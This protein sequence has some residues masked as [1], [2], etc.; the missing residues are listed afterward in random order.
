MSRITL[1]VLVI[2]MTLSICLHAQ[3]PSTQE[4]HANTLQLA[5]EKQFEAPVLNFVIS[6]ENTP[7]IDLVVTTNNVQFLTNE[8]AHEISTKS[9]QLNWLEGCVY[10]VDLSGNGKYVGISEHHYA[11]YGRIQTGSKFS[12]YDNIGNLLTT[13]E[14]T[15]EYKPSTVLNN[16]AFFV[17]GVLEDPRIFLEQLNGENSIIFPESGTMMPSCARDIAQNGRFFVWNFSGI[18]VMYYDDEGNEI[19]RRYVEGNHNAAIAISNYGKYVACFGENLTM[20]SRGGTVLWQMKIDGRK[21]IVS[22]SPDEEFVAV[23]T[24]QEGMRLFEAYTGVLLYHYPIHKILDFSHDASVQRIYSIVLTSEGKYSAC[25]V[26]GGA[27]DNPDA[28]ALNVFVLND[29]GHLIWNENFQN[30][31]RIVPTMRFSDDSK[32]LYVAN[33]ANIYCYR[34]HS[35]D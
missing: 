31:E 7:E 32:Y 5:W 1:Q 21:R 6:N 3:I 35:K 9:Y 4:V 14:V 2:G 11:D 27:G 25:V 29:E 30:D 24:A 13:R 26:G 8:E 23:S 28:G 19:W 34:I 18:G 12:V 16:G 17:T 10:G 33:G 20:F 15:N 22:F